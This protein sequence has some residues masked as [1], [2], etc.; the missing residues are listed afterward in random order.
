MLADAYYI[1]QI[2][3]PEEFKDIKPA[4]K[5]DQIYLK[6]VGEKV[7]SEMTEIFGGFKKMELN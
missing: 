6:F 3:Y 1:A 2:I 7:Y 4:E 5:A